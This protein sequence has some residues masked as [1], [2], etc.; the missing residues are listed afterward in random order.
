MCSGSEEVWCRTCQGR[1]FVLLGS[2][3]GT[4]VIA[5][6]DSRGDNVEAF[7]VLSCGSD[8]AGTLL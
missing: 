7:M 5:V 3:V 4:G 2:I 6:F 1:Q 8:A